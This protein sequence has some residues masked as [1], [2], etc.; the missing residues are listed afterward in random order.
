MSRQRGFQ[1]ID[2]GDRDWNWNLSVRFDNGDEILCRKGA[3]VGK[4]QRVDVGCPVEV[5]TE[6]RLRATEH[7][8]R[9]GSPILRTV[10]RVGAGIEIKNGSRLTR[11][12]GHKFV[13]RSH[14]LD[15]MIEWVLEIWN[16]GWD[17]QGNHPE[18]QV[19]SQD[20]FDDQELG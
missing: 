13:V 12:R 6:R 4:I 20:G 3:V 15:E 7:L 11:Q 2:V 5:D 18:D 16:A 9:V 10:P 1:E 19:L 17:G 8:A 14:L